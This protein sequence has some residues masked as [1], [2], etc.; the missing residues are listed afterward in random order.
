MGETI[1]CM[2]FTAHFLNIKPN[3]E[4]ED[5]FL[6]LSLERVITN[7]YQLISIYKRYARLELGI[8]EEKSSKRIKIIRQALVHAS[9]DIEAIE[10][11]MNSRGSFNLIG[12]NIPRAVRCNGILLGNNFTD[13]TKVYYGKSFVLIRRD[14]LRLV[15]KVTEHY[16]SHAVMHKL[17]HDFQTEGL[18]ELTDVEPPITEPV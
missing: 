2:N 6:K 12:P 9:T 4:A 1:R 16:N 15:C 14:L 7:L 18:Y 10:K 5:A 17:P 11:E 8:E 3:N 13:D